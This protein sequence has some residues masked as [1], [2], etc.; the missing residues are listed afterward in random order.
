M[1]VETHIYDGSAYRK[2]TEIHIYDGSSYRDCNTVH[3]YDGS[4]WRLVF[5]KVAAVVTLSGEIVSD[6][7]AGT[8]EAKL[9]VNADGTIDKYTTTGGWSQIDSS[10]DW[11]IPNGSASSDYDVRVTGVLGTFT[12]SPGTNGDWFTLGSDRTWELSLTGSSGDS[13]QVSFTVEIRDGSD[14]TQ[15]TGS[16]S[17]AVDIL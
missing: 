6:N 5:E 14:V 8:S 15:D 12:A 4:A 2:A 17:L 9:R 10:T 16:Y 7:S 3:V 13:D 11:I 1:A